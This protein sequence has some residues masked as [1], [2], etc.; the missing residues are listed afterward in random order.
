MLYSLS[1]TCDKS[2]GFFWGVPVSSSN[3][4]DLHDITE[5]LLKV[6]LN[7]IAIN[8]VSEVDDKR[9]LIY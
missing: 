3:Q 8:H 4:F 5:I 2:V 9:A 1:V 7:S 6:A